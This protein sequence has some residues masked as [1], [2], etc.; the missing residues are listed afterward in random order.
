MLGRE[1][2]RTVWFNPELYKLYSYKTFIPLQ[3]VCP[4][5]NIQDATLM[6]SPWYSQ[7]DS[8][9]WGMSSVYIPFPR[10]IYFAS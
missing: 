2:S 3:V 10:A 9:P 1:P 7:K 4:L 6:Y 8:S 5:K